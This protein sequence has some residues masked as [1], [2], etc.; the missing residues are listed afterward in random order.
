[1]FGQSSAKVLDGFTDVSSLAVA[2]FGLV[3]C[4]LS[5]LWFGFVLYITVSSRRKAV[6]ALCATRIL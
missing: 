2:A 5:V 3:Y 6:I 4:T 1:M